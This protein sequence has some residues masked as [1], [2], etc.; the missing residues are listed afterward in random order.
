MRHTSSIWGIVTDPQ[1]PGVI[2]LFTILLNVYFF[3]MYINYELGLKTVVDNEN[4]QE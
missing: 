4:K 2:V 3:I 1:N